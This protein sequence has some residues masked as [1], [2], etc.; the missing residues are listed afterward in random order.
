ME[1]RRE[2]GE[3]ITN[4][5]PANFSALSTILQVKSKGALMIVGILDAGKPLDEDCSWTTS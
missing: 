3:A 2:E 4:I 1:Y 5:T